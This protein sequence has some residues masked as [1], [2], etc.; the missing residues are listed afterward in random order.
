MPRP[1]RFVAPFLIPLA[2]CS[3]VQD[4]F[5]RQLLQPPPG[6]LAE[7]ADVG[8]AAEPFEIV[9]HSAASLTGFWIPNERA[10]RR[11]V[12]VFHD[13][14]SNCSV[15]HPYYRF[16]HDA[17]FQVCVFD[18][19]GF[20]RSKGTPTLQAWIHDVPELLDWLHARPD[21]E[22]ERTAYFGTGLGSTAALWA[23]RTQRR[24]AA[25]VLEGLP[26]PR[27]IV[28]ESV[29]D[30]GS[31]LS[32]LTA[33]MVEFAGMP[34]DIEPEEGA[35]RLQIPA[36]FLIGEAEPARDRIALGQSFRAYGGPKHL[37]LLRGTRA[38][39]HALL[40]HDG[41]YQRRIGAFLQAAFAGQAAGPLAAGSKTADLPD[42][43][44][45]YEVQVSGAATDTPVAIEA[46][47]MLV[48][49]TMQFARGWLEHGRA[50][51]RLKLPSAPLA[52]GAADVAAATPD[53]EQVWRETRTPLAEA[54]AAIE[55]LWPRI[56]ELR[57]G[58]L[59]RTEMVALADRLGTAPWP[60]QLEA[61]LADVFA[62]LGRGLVAADD[63]ALRQ[64][65][66]A[67]L[68]RAVAAMPA[69]PLLHWW[70]GATTTWGFPQEAAVQ[71]AK[72]LL[73]APAQ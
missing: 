55:P 14:R 53:P 50:R 65:G 41:E 70:A 35:P 20:G 47:V 6:W 3:S 29:T 7:P 64:R 49:G 16:L 30:D 12:V 54:A 22:P 8:L 44:S 51:V 56:D 71:N 4:D 28:R 36:L 39:P 26:S 60:A 23:A 2:A 10:E 38:A 63:A 1:F 27:A 24:C 61:E 57:N 34:D 42:G 31:A 48:D 68:Q 15:L 5:S 11:T 32:A 69:Q 18:P 19:R 58:A 21:V 52:V 59:G 40:Q 37:W 33:G 46:G 43:R 73:A 25:L 67:L 62:E 17:G 45:W 13:E 9:L 66:A 72:L